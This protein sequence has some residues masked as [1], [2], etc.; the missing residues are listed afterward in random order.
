MDSIFINEPVSIDHLEDK[1]GAIIGIFNTNQAPVDPE[2]KERM[3]I[4]LN[5]Y[6]YDSLNEW[7]NSEV[8]MGCLM[9]WI[10]PEANYEVL[11]YYDRNRELAIT[12]D[13]ILDNRE[14]L[15]SKLRIQREYQKTIT[16]SELIMYAY[17]KW[18]DDCPKHLIG[19]FAFMIWDNKQKRLF[20]ARDFSGTRSLYYFY[21]NGKFVFSTILSPILELPFVDKTHNKEWIAD[22]LA[23][24]QQYDSLN[25]FITP[26]QSIQQVPPAHSISIS[27]ENLVLDR[28]YTFSPGKNLKLNSSS[29]YEEAFIEVLSKAVKS[30][31]R[32]P[33]KVGAQLSGGLDSSSIVSLASKE[34]LKRKRRL[35][36]F[37]HVPIKN[38]KVPDSKGVISDETPLIKS[39][40]NYVGNIEDHYLDLEGRSPLNEIEHWL[41][42]IE[43]PY[44]FVENSFWIRGIYE[45][46]SQENV[47]VLLS[48]ARGN[49]T[50]SWGNMKEHYVALLKKLRIIKLNYELNMLKK[51]QNVNKYAIAKMLLKEAYPFLNIGKRENSNQNIIPTLINPE[52]AKEVD[53]FSRIKGLENPS[54][55]TDRQ[56]RE[57]AYKQLYSWNI[58]GSV[59]TRMSLQHS[60]MERDPTNDLRV[61]NFCFSVPEEQFVRNGLNRALIRQSMKGILPEDVR[62]NN[63]R[64]LQAADWIHRMAPNW[65]CFVSELEQLNSSAE[66]SQF[67]NPK[68]INNA[69]LKAKKGPLNEYES[70][71]DIRLSMR[72]IV[73]E[74][75]LNSKY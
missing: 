22:F 30:R 63:K 74:K 12:A 52:F 5:K 16:D 69:L 45:K 1:M 44:K 49:L 61:I 10:T 54:L 25:T 3:F 7:S 34:L 24:F 56:K 18:K 15:F 35:L 72:G 64:G 40:V 8:F 75:F 57:Y 38:F 17:E 20:G 36:T 13:A 39:T 67:L 21:K 27:G 4:K 28:Y 14:D 31:L 9:Q 66:L 2:E 62:L 53:V 65:D 48:G 32:T 70:D 23:I 6:P 43:M 59:S 55:K 60:V 50:I 11:P 47:K 33:Y 68:L 71:P 51:Q 29:E 58:V 19:D 26:Y 73:L 42:I 46:A 37:S 41:N